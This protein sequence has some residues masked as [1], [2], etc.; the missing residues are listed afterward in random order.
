MLTALYYVYKV[1]KVTRSLQRPVKDKDTKH[2]TKISP[3]E[4]SRAA[5][6]VCVELSLLVSES[7]ICLL[8]LHGIFRLYLWKHRFGNISTKIFDVLIIKLFVNVSTMVWKPKTLTPLH[9]KQNLFSESIQIF[10]FRF[11][12][13]ALFTKIITLTV[14]KKIPLMKR[15]KNIWQ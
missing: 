1:Y 13:F 4:L 11:Y 3:T 12:C 6:E 7:C 8:L 5:R 15:R 2:N 9:L 14:F 10:R